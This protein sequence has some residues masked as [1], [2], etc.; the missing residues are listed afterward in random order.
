MGPSVANAGTLGDGT[1][2]AHVTVSPRAGEPPLDPAAASGLARKLGG[3]VGGSGY[4]IT[5]HTSNVCCAGTGAGVFFELIGEYG[6]S[7]TAR[8]GTGS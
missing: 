1:A 2:T 7:G 6:S 4:K 5:L 8:R 3:G